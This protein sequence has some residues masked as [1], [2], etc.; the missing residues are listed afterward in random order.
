[1]GKNI[2]GKVKVA[3]GASLL[4][5]TLGACGNTAPEVT[6]TAPAGVAADESQGPGYQTREGAFTLDLRQTPLAGLTDE[7]KAKLTAPGS[8]IVT[9]SNGQEFAYANVDGAMLVGGDT[10][11]N[12]SGKAVQELERLEAQAASAGLSG[13]SISI[14]PQNGDNWGNT[15]AYYWT[16]ASSPPSRKPR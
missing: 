2:K 7:Q 11:L 3:F 13:Q 8:V 5:L 6:A 16:L 10:A 1:M 15:I 9:L 14:F 12:R 4:M